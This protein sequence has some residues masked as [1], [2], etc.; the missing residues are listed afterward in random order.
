MTYDTLL[1]GIVTQ[2]ST[3]L[4]GTATVEKVV[5]YKKAGTTAIVYVY[6]NLYNSTPIR[7]RRVNKTFTFNITVE[8]TCRLETDY[9]SLWGVAEKI[10]EVFEVLDDYVVV[11]SIC[12]ITRSISARYYK[13]AD[14]MAYVVISVSLEQLSDD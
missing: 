11:N 9:V 4:T 13:D 2:L 14:D 1:T 10:Y 7:L 6:P 3:K 12:F 5:P 8:R